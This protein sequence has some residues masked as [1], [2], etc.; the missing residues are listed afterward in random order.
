MSEPDPRAIWRSST[1]PGSSPNNATMVVVGDTTLDE[2]KPK[3]EKLFGGWKHGQ[4]RRR[5]S[6][7]S[8]SGSQPDGLPDRPAR[9]RCSRSSSPAT[10]RR[11]RADTDEDI[12]IEAMNEVLGGTLHRAHQHEPARGQALVLRRPQCSSTPGASGPSSSYAPVQTDKTKESMAEIQRELRDIAGPRPPTEEE[13]TRAKDKKTLTLPGRW[14]T[15]RAVRHSVA[16]MVRHGLPDDYWIQYPREIRRLDPAEVS[17]VAADEIHP[18][19]L[20]WVVVGDRDEIEPGIRELGL[21]EVVILDATG[22]P[23]EGV[24]D[25]GEPSP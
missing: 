13:L 17:A 1:R 3:L 22:T 21:G 9:L 5:T 20:I 25:P 4:A 8:S 18:D 6:P 19:R 16:E 2:I 15:A 12:A 24:E 11:L 7:R 14:E 23:A 10:W